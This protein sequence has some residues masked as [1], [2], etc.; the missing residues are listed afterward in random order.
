VSLLVGL[1]GEKTRRSQ[2]A[3]Q[4]RPRLKKLV[5]VPLALRRCPTI[6][7][8]IGEEN[9]IGLGSARREVRTDD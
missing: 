5:V 6:Y 9:K 4:N 2:L 7:F 8:R 1:A 3:L